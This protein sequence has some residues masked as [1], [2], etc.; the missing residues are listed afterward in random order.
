MVGSVPLGHCRVTD[1]EFEP[2][3]EADVAVEL[4]PVEPIELV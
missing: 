2:G 4:L 1:V 3:V